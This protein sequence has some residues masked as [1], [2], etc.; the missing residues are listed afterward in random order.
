M[1]EWILNA[2][3]VRCLEFVFAGDGRSHTMTLD[4]DLVVGVLFSVLLVGVE[5]TGCRTSWGHASFPRLT[6]ED[7]KSLY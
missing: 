6:Q 2:Q 1:S 4:G 3:T 7:T 5:Q